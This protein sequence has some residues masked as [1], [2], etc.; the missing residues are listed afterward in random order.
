MQRLSLVLLVVLLVVGINAGRKHEKEIMSSLTPLNPPSQSV[1][2]SPQVRNPDEY[3]SFSFEEPVQVPV[4]FSSFGTSFFEYFGMSSLLYLDDE[5]PVPADDD[6][7]VLVDDDD[8]GDDE[9]ADDDDEGDIVFN[10]VGAGS[11]I[12]MS[13][14]VIFMST[15]VLV[16]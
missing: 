6:D 4:R 13:L 14:T 16:C 11:I 9:D 8:G 2:P 15:I 7:A 10:D 12:T 3:V 5:D 1:T